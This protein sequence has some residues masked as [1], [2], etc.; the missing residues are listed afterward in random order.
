MAGF[1]NMG[2]VRV[3][4][5]VPAFN[6]EKHLWVVLKSLL[7][8]KKEGVIQRI[9]VVDDGSTDG[10]AKVAAEHGAEV[11]RLRKNSGKAAAFM[12]GVRKLARQTQKPDFLVTLDADLEPFHPDEI[13][14]MVGR[15]QHK[16]Y[17]KRVVGR[18]EDA[19]GKEYPNQF[20]GQRAFVFS[21]LQPLLRRNRRL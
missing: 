17:L 11:I 7:R 18:I 13:K 3:A 10:T 2:M 19:H 5:L 12:V 4:V 21:A 8:A 15:L 9:L 1:R 14:K 16:P 6:E 20:N